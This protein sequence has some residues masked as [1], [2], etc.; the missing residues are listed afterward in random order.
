MGIFFKSQQIQDRGDN[1]KLR[2]PGTSINVTN[3]I[4][5]SRGWTKQ[6]FI[7]HLVAWVVL[8]R[9]RPAQTPRPRNYRDTAWQH[10][11][12]TDIWPRKMT[13]ELPIRQR[14]FGLTTFII[15]LIMLI[16]FFAYTDYDSEAKP[17]SYPV[18]LSAGEQ[19]NQTDHRWGRPQLALNGPVSKM[20]LINSQ[21]DNQMTEHGTSMYFIC[22]H[23]AYV[24][25]TLSRC[26][27]RKLSLFSSSCIE[28]YFQSIIQQII[29]SS[30]NF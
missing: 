10:R 3:R 6:S 5:A 29:L 25:A 12:S 20:N 26:N 15:Q 17:E 8:S 16:L 27:K 4:K 1:N 23:T 18:G 22:I 9:I 19:T 13:K 30:S 7:L 11:T 24:F 14:K 21:V 28:D 2:C